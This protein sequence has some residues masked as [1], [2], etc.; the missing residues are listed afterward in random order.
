[1]VTSL[2]LA[3]SCRNCRPHASCAGLVKL[4]STNIADELRDEHRTR[5]LED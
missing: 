1:M 4:S 2:I 5:V 3:L